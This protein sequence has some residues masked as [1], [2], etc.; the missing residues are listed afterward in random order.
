MCEESE[1]RLS[2]CSLPTSYSEESTKESVVCFPIEL[3]NT[4]MGHEHNG[5]QRLI[6]DILCFPGA[7]GR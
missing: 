7:V 2:L 4:L 1:R 6:F 5:S 3:P